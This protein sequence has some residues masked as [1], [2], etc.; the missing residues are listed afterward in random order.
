MLKYF[1]YSA[2]NK[3]TALKLTP[4]AFFTF[5]KNFTTKNFEVIYVACI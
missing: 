2:L 5:L 1:I 4:L 3:N